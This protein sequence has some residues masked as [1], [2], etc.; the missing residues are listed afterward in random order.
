MKYTCR[1]LYATLGAF[2]HCKMQP[3]D[4]EKFCL[5]LWKDVQKVVNEIS[6]VK[7]QKSPRYRVLNIYELS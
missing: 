2:K 4:V 5:A 1:S 7:L 6:Q 3:G